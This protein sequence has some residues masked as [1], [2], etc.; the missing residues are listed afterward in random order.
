MVA[1]SIASMNVDGIRDDDKRAR[2][3]EYL[4]SLKHDF[5]LIQ[6]T[7][8]QTEDV[9]AWSA[10]WGVYASGISVATNPGV[11]GILCNVSLGFEDLEVRRDFYGCLVNVKLSLHDWKF[12][13][14][15]VYALNDPRGRSEFFSDLWRHMF[16]G[17]PLF[18]GGDFNCIENLELDKAGGDALA[19]DKGS[20]ELKGF[21]DSVSLCDVFRV[22]FPQR[23]L[24]TRHNKTNTNMSRIDQIYAPKG[25]IPDAFG[26]TF[27]LCSYSDHDLVSVK[28]NC[29]QTLTH[30]P[31]LLKFNSSLTQD[32]DYTGLMTKFLQGWKLQK[33]RYPDLRTWWDVGKSHIRTITVE[34]A[35]AKRREKRSLR[36]N[37]VSQLCRAEQEPAPSAGVI[38]DLR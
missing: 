33:E 24:F 26:Y 31:G 22:K 3:F 37:L 9:E 11:W 28:F 23:K 29:K 20:A 27:N 12:Q 30:G 1:F 18:L 8:V 17:I 5:F 35:T 25:M 38:T 19:G 7:H 4:R 15:C 36:S 6:E 34:F 2:I 14:M 16:P 13:V 21:V 32:D 10:E